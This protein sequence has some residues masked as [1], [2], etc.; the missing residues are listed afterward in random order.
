M[1]WHVLYIVCTVCMVSIRDKYTVTDGSLLV[2]DSP[3]LELGSYN[4]GFK[5]T[6][7]T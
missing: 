3:V 6:D 4:C 5:V 7:F 1:A 2:I